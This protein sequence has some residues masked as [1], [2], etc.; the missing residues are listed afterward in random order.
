MWHLDGG[1][2]ICHVDGS[3]HAVRTN[4]QPIQN[5]MAE[6]ATQV[7]IGSTFG[8]STQTVLQIR[9]ALPKQSLQEPRHDQDTQLSLNG[10]EMQSGSALSESQPLDGVPPPMHGV[11]RKSVV[12]FGIV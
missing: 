3:S 5:L 8:L 2:G 11:A 9:R 6:T 1:I 4:R 10:V 7:S 12:E